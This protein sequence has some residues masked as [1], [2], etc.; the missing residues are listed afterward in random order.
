MGILRLQKE[1]GGLHGEIGG[2]RGEVD[3]LH[4]EVDELRGEIRRLDTRTDEMNKRIESYFRWTVGMM[5]M[6]ASTLA[7][8]IPILLRVV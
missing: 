3:G 8:L 1:I 6:W 5:G 2:L 7:I 4:S